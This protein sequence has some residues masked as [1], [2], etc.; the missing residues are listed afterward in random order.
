M[1]IV[2]QVLKLL[3]SIGLFLYG[4]TLMSEGLQKVAGEKMRNVL[5]AM[6]SNSFKRVLTGLFITSI[7]QSSSATTVMVVSFVNAGLLTLTQSVGVI[8][9]A[10]IGTTVTAWI[11]SLLGFKFDISM[12]SI[13]LIGFGFALMML[14]SR[15]K[16]SI[17]ELIIGFAL[18][19]LG[20]TFLKDSVPDLKSNPEIFAFLQQW[21]SFGF[22]SV[23]IFVLIGSILTMVM[24][25]SSATMALTLVMASYGWIPFELAA[26][27]VLG[28]N[29]G[30]TITANIAA[31]VANVSARRAAL[32]HTVFNVFGVIWVLALYKP[33]MFVVS[34]VTIAVFSIDPYTNT[35]AIL[36]GISFLHTLFNLT[37]TLLLI[38]FT[39]QIVKLVTRVIKSKETEEVFRLKYIQ[40]GILSTAELSLTQAKQEIVDFAKLG[41]QQFIYARESLMVCETDKFEELYN[42]LEHY[43]QITD[44][45]ELEI[46]NY[47]NNISEGELSEESARRLQAM[48]TIISEIESIG[49]SGYNIARIL[50]RKKI[51]GKSFTPDMVK[52]LDHMFVILDKAF[53]NMIENLNKGYTKIEDISNAVDSE[54]EINEYRNIL[55]EE[56]LLSLEHNK[57]NYQTGVY[58]MDIVAECEMTGDYIIN[59]SEAIIEIQ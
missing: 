42:K 1:D 46:A 53:N 48:Y 24:Q 5:A 51:H 23:L 35:E 44:K 57:Y 52:K 18:L 55:K 8:M 58:Y 21:T 25:S 49:D 30:T 47:L 7:I 37:N 26:A 50:N 15:K 43:E 13:P 11:I 19:F 40:G 41:K 22:G 6:T 2:F 33:V 34:K 59:V 45:V 17:G 27:M 29:I 20:L 10:N 28:E 14:K 32:A 4:M 16:K 3:G 38:W 56:H 12:F 31:A 39:P 36:Y 54:E 9:G